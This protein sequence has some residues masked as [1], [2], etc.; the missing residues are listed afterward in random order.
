MKPELQ[1]GSMVKVPRTGGGTSIGRITEFPCTGFARVEFP[2][3][4]TYRGK[5]SPFKDRDKTAHKTV[6]ISDLTRG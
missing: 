6:P 2:L 4:S 1:I 5:P 3:G